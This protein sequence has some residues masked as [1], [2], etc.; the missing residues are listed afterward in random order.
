MNW[1]F[2][3]PRDIIDSCLRRV[4]SSLAVT[5]AD[6]ESDDLAGSIFERV[7]KAISLKA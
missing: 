5:A 1:V 6:G 2:L 3:A 7:T 4:K